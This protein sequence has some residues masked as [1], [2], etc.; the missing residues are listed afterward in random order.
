MY[1][2]IFLII[3]LVLILISAIPMLVRIYN[4]LIQ[5]HEQIDRAWKNIDI[6]LEQRFEEI[7]KLISI[8]E[9][10]V[11]YESKVIKELVEARKQYSQSTQAAD[12]IKCANEVSEKLQSLFMIAENYPQ[13]NSQEQFLN[14]QKRISSL[15]SQIAD[16]KELVNEVITQYNARIKMFPDF[17]FANFLKFSPIPLYQIDEAKRREPSL[18]L[19]IP[20]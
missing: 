6:I 16:R 4:N 7:P 8:V 11:G 10:Y 9:Q 12:Q 5:L 17:F 18:E 2:L 19:K 3:L 20:S 14:L 1:S 13:L 15:E